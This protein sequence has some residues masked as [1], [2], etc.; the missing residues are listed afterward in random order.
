MKTF[1]ISYASS[2]CTMLVID[3]VW[4][5]IMVNAFYVR[6]LGHLMVKT[7]YIFP[8]ILFYILYALALTVLVVMPALEHSMSL[9]KV[10]CMG[11]LFG[12]AAYATYDLTNQATIQGWPLIVTLVDL[13]WGTVL[14]GVVSV[15]AVYITKN[16]FN[17]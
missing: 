10:L 13:L 15:S 5:G 12:C 9:C 8:V 7:P 16:I 14:T 1:I 4:L 11:A 3:G 17:T 2:L 6:H